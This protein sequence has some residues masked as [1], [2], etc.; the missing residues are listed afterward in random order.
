LSPSAAG[1]AG[2]ARQERPRVHSDLLAGIDFEASVEDLHLFY[3]LWEMIWLVF[4]R[5]HQASIVI[6]GTDYQTAVR[7]CLDRLSAATTALS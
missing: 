1:E 6:T 4:R 7:I 5:K 2:V 3:T